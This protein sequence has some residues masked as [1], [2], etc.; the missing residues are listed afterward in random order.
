[1]AFVVFCRRNVADRG[2]RD[3]LRQKEKPRFA[4]ILRRNT[5]SRAPSPPDRPRPSP[6]RAPHSGRNRV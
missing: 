3:K 1:M 2:S 4:I 6:D 5:A